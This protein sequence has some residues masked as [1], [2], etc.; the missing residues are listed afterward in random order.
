MKVTTEKLP[1]SQVSLTIEVPAELSGKAYEDTVK[2]YA[3]TARIPGF[4]Q[5]KVPR[6]VLLRQLGPEAL[7]AA[8]LDEVV[9]LGLKQALKQEDIRP[10]G[11]AQVDT[12]EADMFSKFVPGE[13]FTFT[14][15]LDVFPDVELPEY[16]GLSVKA[17]EEKP[18]PERLDKLLKEQQVQAATLIPV[19]DRAAQLGDVAI[20]DYQGELV[21][22]EGAEEG[23]DDE[24]DTAGLTAEDFQL[25]LEEDQFIPG[26]ISGIVGMEPDDIKEIEVSFPEDYG[27]EDLAGRDVKFK[28]TLHE[29]KER[30]LPELT[31]EFIQTISSYDTIDALR[32][33]MDKQFTEEAENKTAENKKRELVKAL[34]EA[35][36]MELPET[37]IDQESTYLVNQ[38]AM[39][40]Q[41]QGLDVNQFMTKEMVD[42]MKE[43]SRPDA[44]FQVKSDLVI[45]AI[46]E[47]EELKVDEKE[48]RVKV[49]EL[50]QELKGQNPK[51][52]RV[53]SVIYEDMF[54]NLVIDFLVEKNDFEMVPAGS[55]APAEEESEEAASE[56]TVEV[57]A[58][59]AETGEEE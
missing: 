32:E 30:E 59:T 13:A 25:D 21:P 45:Q 43:R 6:Q 50:M 41:Q 57:A 48:L 49:K 44:I 58:E 37:L 26:F 34:V 55:L 47:K 18:D 22:K 1:A 8:S 24:I 4:R 20:V 10:A 17:E 33:A 36:E 29:I 40:L 39:Q 56:A 35:T 54:R 46:G 23:A 3:K 12:S 42:N 31:D 27:M 9:E 16:T 53:E 28:I 7:K 5:G 2:K 19:E 38:A 11:Q 15:K 14:V 51:R 52:S